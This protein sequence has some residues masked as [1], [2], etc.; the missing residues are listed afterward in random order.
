MDSCIWES[1]IGRLYIGADD[2]GVCAVRIAE[3][4]DTAPL[5]PASGLLCAAVCQLSEYMSGRRETFDLPLSLSGTPFER[6]VWAQLRAIPYGETMT[7]GQLATTIGR[8]GAS[9]AVG[10]ACGANPVL[11]F[12]P[13]HR[14]I[15]ADGRL[16]GFA[17]G[18]DAKRAL[19]VLEGHEVRMDRILRDE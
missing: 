18:L 14:V 1:P 17:A 15:G 11:V 13:C 9:R 6:E 7:Y 16:T 5:P 2:Y 12:V 3:E 4:C 19:L 8:P 10:R